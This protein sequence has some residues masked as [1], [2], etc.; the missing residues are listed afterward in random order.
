M[1]QVNIQLFEAVSLGD[2]KKWYPLQARKHGENVKPPNVL[3][4]VVNFY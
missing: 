3:F 1:G 4:F 2:S